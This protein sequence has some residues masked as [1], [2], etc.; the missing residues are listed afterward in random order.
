MGPVVRLKLRARVRANALA[1]EL[2]ALL[3]LQH[4][5]G[6]AQRVNGVAARARKPKCQ[7]AGEHHG[8]A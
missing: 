1:A 8:E 5:A 3:G 2:C 6:G 4:V 7:Q